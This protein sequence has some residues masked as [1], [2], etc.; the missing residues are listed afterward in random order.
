[1]QNT[2]AT[3]GGV[4]NIG[5]LNATNSTL[6]RNTAANG[7][8]LYNNSGSTTLN[9]VTIHLSIGLSLYANGGTVT[10]SNTILS[11]AVSYQT[12]GGTG[13]V[14]TNGYNLAADQTCTFLT[15][16]SD[17]TG[18]DPVLDGIIFP[19]NGAAYHLP[20]VQSPAVN[21]GNPATP[22][23][24]STACLVSDQRGQE[25]PLNKRCDIGA[26]EV[27]VYRIFIPIILE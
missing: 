15:A 25:R 9:N 18:Q 6:S 10:L 17:I 3:G 2:G 21:A 20:R 24:S 22:G 7:A 12:C 13:Q 27:L 14:I 8:G 23:S 16:P 4:Y 1:V 5:T 11:S 19:A 26:V